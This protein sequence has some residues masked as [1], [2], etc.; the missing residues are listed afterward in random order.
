MNQEKID[1]GT[2][3]LGAC[4]KC[5]LCHAMVASNISMVKALKNDLSVLVV[6]HIINVIFSNII[7]WW[8]QNP[9]LEQQFEKLV[10]W[11]VHRLHALFVET[12]AIQ[13]WIVHKE[14]PIPLLPRCVS[15]HVLV[16]VHFCKLSHVFTNTTMYY[17]VSSPLKCC[18]IKRWTLSNSFHQSNFNTYCFPPTR[19][20]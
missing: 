19:V 1:I 4:S 12:E 15:N 18:L 2:N 8:A 7:I 5:Y 16:V 9:I 10:C 6:R 3:L 13:S 17:S 11:Y 14:C 20:V